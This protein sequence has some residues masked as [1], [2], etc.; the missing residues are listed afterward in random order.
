MEFLSYLTENS[1][2][3]ISLLLE[4][5]E[6]TLLSVVLSIIIGDTNEKK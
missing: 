5:I 6:L 1:S 2:Q 4:H 3:I